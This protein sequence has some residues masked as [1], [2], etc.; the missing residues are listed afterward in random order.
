MDSDLFAEPPLVWLLRIEVIFFGL[1]AVL[2]AAAGISV[3]AMSIRFRRCNIVSDKLLE[4]LQ[5][6]SSPRVVQSVIPHY[7]CRLSQLL[8]QAAEAWE[9]HASA[10]R[11]LRIVEENWEDVRLVWR[12]HLNGLN[13]WA[14]AALLVGGLGTIGEI[15]RLL[16]AEPPLE[17]WNLLALGLGRSLWPFFIGLSTAIPAWLLHTHL[18]GKAERLLFELKKH[19]DAITAPWENLQQPFELKIPKE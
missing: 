10:A 7:K 17:S 16:S 3:L 1:Q 9:Q 19:A 6:Y 15:A 12:R 14:R 18:Q 5:R 11:V 4:S 2:F 8:R 13:A